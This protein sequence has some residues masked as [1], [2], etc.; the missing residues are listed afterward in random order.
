MMRS[1]SLHFVPLS[2]PRCSSNRKFEFLRVSEMLNSSSSCSPSQDLSLFRPYSRAAFRETQSHS[3]LKGTLACIRQE[4]SDTEIYT[5]P[6]F[7]L[8][9]AS[10]V[11]RDF[12]DGINRRELGRVE[13]LMGDGCIYEDLI[14]S[15]PFVGRKAILEFFKRF[16]E[17]ISSELQFIIDDISD[18]DTTAVGVTWHL[19]WRGRPFPFS[20]GCSFYRLEV[21]NGTRKIIYARD[22]VEPAFKPGTTALA[23][24]SAVTWLLQ[25]FPQLV[26]K[27]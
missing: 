8:P 19:E 24:I 26:D 23:I 3:H 11:V 21:S 22:C 2:W 16:T 9:S 1:H 4:T 25:R 15:K 5:A 7:R 10:E 12:Y 20:K 6:P 18:E 27:F 17:S 13:H 14:F